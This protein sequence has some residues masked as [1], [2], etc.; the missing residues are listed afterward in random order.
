MAETGRSF[1]ELFS[2]YCLDPLERLDCYLK[3][4]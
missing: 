3:S 1:E 2:V 4:F